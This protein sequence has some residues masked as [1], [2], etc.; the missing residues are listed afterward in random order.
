MSVT[1]TLPLY[2]E[3][4]NPSW[5][6]N[7]LQIEELSIR[8]RLLT[9]TVLTNLPEIAKESEYSGFI[10]DTTG[11]LSL[12]S[13]I[14]IYAGIVNLDHLDIKAEKISGLEEW[15]LSTG[16]KALDQ[17]EIDYVKGK[18]LELSIKLP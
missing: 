16:D 4:P 9:D 14:H 11:V 17:E 2:S 7:D 10:I 18:I 12:N 15:L 13:H 3:R 5:E 8:I 1:V 6:L